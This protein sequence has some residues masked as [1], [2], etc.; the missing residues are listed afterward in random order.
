MNEINLT[1][2]IDLMRLQ[3][4]G[5]KDIPTRNG[6]TKRCIVIPI[7]ENDIFITK[8]E[9]TGKTKSAYFGMNI[10]QRLEVSKFGATHYAKPAVSNKFAEKYPALAEER[11]NTYVGDFKP[12]VFEGGN[13]AN[14]V[15]AEVVQRDENDDLPF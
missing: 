6:D 8:D 1:G 12:Y 5:T 2:S 13:A 3:S 14:S 4:V 9:L 11:R 15:A 7:E 10:N